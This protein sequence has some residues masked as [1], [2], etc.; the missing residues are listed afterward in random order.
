MLAR[1][2]MRRPTPLLAASSLATRS[3]AYT[4]ETQPF[5]FINEHTKVICQGMTGKHVSKTRHMKDELV[6]NSRQILACPFDLRIDSPVF[7][8]R[9]LGYFP[10]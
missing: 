1:G 8:S 2:V 10:H 9:F 4:A 6:G 7:L 3:F 5:V